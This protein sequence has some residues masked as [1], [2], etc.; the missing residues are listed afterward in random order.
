M[1]AADGE[2]AAKDWGLEAGEALEKAASAATA[3][4]AGVAA[5][6]EVVA[7]WGLEAGEGAAAV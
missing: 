2:A 3:E 6:A 7:G 4:A 5:T 1:E